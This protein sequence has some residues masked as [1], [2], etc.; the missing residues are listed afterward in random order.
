MSDTS[1]SPA[2][3]APRAPAMARVEYLARVL[4]VYARPASGPLSFWHEEPE[5]N[6]A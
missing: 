3:R 6:E 4:Q 1:A 5:V 2:V